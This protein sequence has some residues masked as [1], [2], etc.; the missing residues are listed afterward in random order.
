MG[1]ITSPIYQ[2]PKNPDFPRNDPMGDHNMRDPMEG[3]DDAVVP[4]PEEGIQ[5]NIDPNMPGGPMRPMRR[6]AP[7][8]LDQQSGVNALAGG[9]ALDALESEVGK[10]DDETVEDA[11]RRSL[12]EREDEEAQR[13]LE[14]ITGVGGKDQAPVP[15]DFFRGGEAAVD[16][17]TAKVGSDVYGGL[18]RGLDNI[19]F[20]GPM[21]AV[22]SFADFFQSDLPATIG[23]PGL[24]ET[25]SLIWRSPEEVKALG[26]DKLISLPNINGVM[27][28]PDTVTGALLQGFTQFATGFAAAGNVIGTAR[29]A[30]AATQALNTLLRAGLADVLAFPGREPNIAN[31]AQPY[32]QYVPALREATNFLAVDEETPE[33]VGRLKR[34][35][36][37]TPLNAAFEGVLA[38]LR[39]VKVWRH[40]QALAQARGSPPVLPSAGGTGAAQIPGLPGAQSGAAARPSAEAIVGLPDEALVTRIEQDI[41]PYDYGVPMQVVA[42][43]LAEAPGSHKAPDVAPGMKRIYRVE[44]PDAPGERYEDYVSELGLAQAQKA[45]KPGSVIIYHDIPAHVRPSMTGRYVL[46]NEREGEIAPPPPFSRE[47]RFNWSH[48][49]TD[50]DMK[51][52]AGQV[53]DAMAD[54]L[55]AQGVGVTQTWRETAQKANALSAIDM[56]IGEGAKKGRALDAVQLE[57]AGNIYVTALKDLKAVA[58]IAVQPNAGPED[59]LAFDHMMR[60]FVMAQ[61]LFV[62]ARTEAGRALNILRKAKTASSKYSDDLKIILERMGG[63]ETLRG[64]AEALADLLRDPDGA[65]KAGHAAR[66][67]VTARTL[68]V[69]REIWVNN[70]FGVKTMIVNTMGNS[71]A[72]AVQMINRAVA[73]K[74]AP[75]LDPIDGVKAGEALAMWQGV[76]EAQ[77]DA[78][79]IF[80]RTWKS[81]DPGFEQL[82]MNRLKIDM[83]HEPAFTAKGL[84]VK[85]TLQGRAVDALGFL[86]TQGRWTTRLM[87]STDAYFKAVNY[88]AELRA[89]AYRMA[90]QEL[91]AGTLPPDGVKERIAAILADP[92]DNIKLKAADMAAYNTFTNEPGEAIKWVLKARTVPIIRGP[93]FFITPFVATPAN[94][95]KYSFDHSPLAPL[96]AKFRKAMAA[97]GAERDIALAKVGLGSLVMG[98]VYDMALSGMITGSG[99]TGDKSAGER[100]ALAREGVQR[101]S[102]RVQTGT[103]KDG[104]P[105]YRYFAYNRL[106]PMGMLMGTAADMAEYAMNTDTAVDPQWEEAW[107]AGI[108]ATAENLMKKT[109]LMGAATLVDALH[110]PQRYGEGYFERMAASFVPTDVAEVARITDPYMKHTTDLVSA[111]KVRLPYWSK[112][113][114]N[115]LNLWGEPIPFQS[116]LGTAYDYLSPIYSR[117]TEK[118]TAIDREFLAIEYFPQDSIAIDLKGTTDPRSLNVPLRNRPEIVHDLKFTAGQVPA[119][120]LLDVNEDAMR[121]RGGVY[122]TYANQL[123]ELGDRTLKEA[124]NDLV[125][126]K[127][128]L[129]SADYAAATDAESKKE[130]I[131]DILQ[132]YRGAAKTQIIR[133]HPE[134]QEMRD[135]IPARAAGR[136][137]AETSP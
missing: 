16:D 52:M 27:D 12:Q 103:E 68:D 124:L 59:L 109:Y 119:S 111:L 73:G 108:F 86:A 132:A 4:R 14:E 53:M 45:A 85:G 107:A 5:W 11:Y 3:P 36:A 21:R 128:D 63:E 110:D 19:A 51:L 61:N 13:W 42:K 125:T 70:I 29:N 65:V 47:F 121:E 71:S 112:D 25:G 92:P 83:R 9:S 43:A 31:L 69:V 95:V 133:A 35:I 93:A 46:R 23:G 101:Y 113:V 60:A 55:R 106:D 137:P 54:D 87:A 49:E 84:D 120:K 1:T 82:G 2:D 72:L 48:I 22:Q 67:M 6:P 33:M 62:P 75:W 40:D 130:M 58:D 24:D 26:K 102:I 118:A 90:S 94:L 74:I 96:S 66:K 99:P 100:R 136:G 44:M 17:I 117:S 37:D 81:G 91:D 105:V 115:V 64:K 38:G 131:E 126:G 89:Q 56:L 18:T 57:A 15:A 39:R 10:E 77:G 114:P 32:V 79:R 116:G 127:L 8:P 97:G 76:K 41:T 88:R 78:L 30:G 28:T 7:M 104:T 135:R 123:E 34:A 134:L 122:K 129:L 80:A 98:V 20:G 50:D